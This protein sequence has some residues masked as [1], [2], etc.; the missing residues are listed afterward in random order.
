MILV[1][2]GAG[3]I[4]SHTV[5]RLLNE[6]F[7]VVVVD[8]LSNSSIESV[9]RVEK[10]A[11]RRVSFEEVNLQDEIALDRVFEK[12]QIESV[13]HFAGLKAVSESLIQPLSYYG[14]NVSGTICLLR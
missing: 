6:G 14:N 2:G 9:R 4:G 3:Y 7:D 13:I 5:L 12:Y 8:N 10:L 1:T 11:G